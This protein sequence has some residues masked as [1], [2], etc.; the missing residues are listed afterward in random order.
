MYA[1]FIQKINSYLIGLKNFR[2]VFVV[3]KHKLCLG[4]VKVLWNLH[5]GFLVGEGA[6]NEQLLSLVISCRCKASLRT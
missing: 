6:D 4:E 2:V 3:L 5:L 1:L